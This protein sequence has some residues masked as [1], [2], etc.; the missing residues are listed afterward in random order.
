[1]T[2]PQYRYP[3]THAERI[4]W[5]ERGTQ[6]PFTPY[7]GAAPDEMRDGLLRGFHAHNKP[8]KP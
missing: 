4:A 2:A 3:D 6:A 7:T 5:L 1:M 8:E